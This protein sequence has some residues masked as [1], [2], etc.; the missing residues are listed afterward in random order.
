MRE[1]YTWHLHPPFNNEFDHSH[2]WEGQS[3]IEPAAALYELARRHPRIGQLWLK[4]KRASWYGQELRCPLVGAAE[5]KM[6]SQAFN[7]LGKESAAIHC[8]CLIG[9]N[10]WPKLHWSDQEYW[11]DTAGKIKGLDCRPDIGQCQNI[12]AQA[13]GELIGKRRFRLNRK[14]RHKRLTREEFDA[15]VSKDI[16][17]NPFG[18]DEWNAAITRHAIE[19]LHKGHLLFSVAPDLTLAEA[20]NLFEREYGLHRKLTLEGKQRARWENWLPLIAAFENEEAQPGGKKSPAFI[21]YRRTLDGV[22][23][24]PRPGASVTTITPI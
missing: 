21:R 18:A 19:E 11:L 3:K 7:D 16:I 1:R 10:S 6:V 23:F 12:N 13:G 24:T 2:W 15:L 9:L 22:R 20:K 5:K 4:F 17:K 14:G 8:L